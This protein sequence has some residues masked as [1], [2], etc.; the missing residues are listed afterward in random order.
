MFGVLSDAGLQDVS[1]LEY[2]DRFTPE[3]AGS[4]VRGKTNYPLASLYAVDNTCRSAFGFASTGY[5]K[6]ICP[7]IIQPAAGGGDGGGEA[8]SGCQEPAGGC[9]EGFYWW[10]DP[11]C[12]CSATPYNQ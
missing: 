2:V 1:Q 8:A 3:E 7:R 10:P 11:H 5:E 12:A 6:R 9:G 4:P